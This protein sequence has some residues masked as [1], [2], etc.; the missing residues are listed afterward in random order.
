MKKNQ[1][2]VPSIHDNLASQGFRVSKRVVVNALNELL[3]DDTNKMFAVI[4]NVGCHIFKYSDLLAYEHIEDGVV[5]TAG[6]GAQS[7]VGSDT[8]GATTSNAVKSNP[9]DT[10]KSVNVRILLNNLN[11]SQLEIPCLFI[12]V[13]KNQPMYATAVQNASEI[14]STLNYILNQIETINPDFKSNVNSTLSFI[15]HTTQN[16]KP[17]KGCAIGCLVFLLIFSAIFTIAVINIDPVASENRRTVNEFSSIDA[18]EED[19]LAIKST[20]EEIGFYPFETITYDETLEGFATYTDATGYGTEDG[21][22]IK[23]NDNITNAIIYI[24]DNNK[25]IQAKYNEVLYIDNYEVKDHLRNHTIS[26]E[27]M[28]HYINL[29]KSTI[30]SI[31]KSPKSADFPFSYDEYSFGKENGIFYIQGYVDAQNSFGAE[32]RS[33]YTVGYISEVPV[34]V[35]FDDEVLLDERP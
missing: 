7:F 4:N 19:V 34:Y 27:E 20:L 13:K 30:G 24:D 18:P 3:V 26:S 2:T 23:I 31:L 12:P 16:I 17:K 5:I 28:S 29:T 15:P 9:K 14:S 33:T 21:Y 35:V 8:F 10:C 22:R 1:Q 32:I 25:I 11:K 6:K